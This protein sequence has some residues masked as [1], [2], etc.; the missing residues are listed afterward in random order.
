MGELVSDETPYR[1]HLKDQECLAYHILV[2]GLVTQH[3]PNRKS[4]VGRSRHKA[5]CRFTFS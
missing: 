5:R 4:A 1:S 2:T 3:N